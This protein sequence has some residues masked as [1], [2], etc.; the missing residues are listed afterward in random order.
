MV[1][2][3][4]IW[5][6]SLRDRQRKK[7]KQLPSVSLKS[8]RPISAQRP[9]STIYPKLPAGP[10]PANHL[11]NSAR[12]QNAAQYHSTSKEGAIYMPLYLCEKH[13]LHIRKIYYE[14][15]STFGEGSRWHIYVCVMTDGLTFIFGSVCFG[16]TS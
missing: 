11:L 7:Q 6:H 5:G 1:L 2:S 16:V 8:N 14:Q 12:K 4:L 15:I 9:C 13:S 10:Q 3:R